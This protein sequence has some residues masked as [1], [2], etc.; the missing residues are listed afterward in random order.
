MS[1]YQVTL[2]GIPGVFNNGESV[3]FPYRKAEGIC[4]YLCV[5]KNANRDE[6]ISIFWGSS[7]EASG[8]KNLRQALFQIRQSMDTDVILMQGK[9][10]L[11]LNS[12]HG[13]HIDWDAPDADFSL[14]KERFLDFF[15]LKDCPE[16]EAWVENK[17][18]LQ[19]TRCLDYIKGQLKDP[20]IYHEIP[21]LR[22]LIDTW[23]YWKPWD[24]EMV[25]TGMR[26]YTQ[27]EKYDLGIQLYH[28][29]ERC[30]RKDLEEEPSHAVELLFRTLFHRK[31]VSLMRK[32]DHKEFFFGRLA[33]LQYIDERIFWFLNN[34][35][36]SSV[37]IEGEVGVGKT[38]LMQQIFEMNRDV[39][40]LE[41]VSHSYSAEAKFPLKSWRDLFNQ[42]EKLQNEGKLHLSEENAKLIQFVLTGMA[43]ELLDVVHDGDMEY[44]GYT[45]LE[46][47]VLTLLKELSGRWKIILYFDSLQ[48]MD[49]VS[50]RLLQRIMIEFGNNQVFMIATC[51]VDGQQDIRGFLAALSERDIIT[52]LSLSCFT[53]IETK[54]IIADVLQGRRDD[55][56]NARELF[57]RT[58]GNALVL[59]DTLNMVRQNGWK[60]GS[61]LPRI[62][63]LI[64][65][66]LESLTKQQRKVL[67]ALSVY[68][69]HAELEE[70]E[71]LVEMD[72]MELIEILEQLLLFHFVT[73]EAWN[74]CIIYKFTHRFYKDYVYQ[75]LSLGKRRLWH[76]AVA[77]FYEKQKDEERWL[78]LLPFTIFHY[79]CCGN[80]E[81][82]DAL[83]NLQNNL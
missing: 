70:L 6:L 40:I 35:S 2:L 52:T 18:N 59:M 15:Y 71:L 66:W 26:C 5:E 22:R 82:A 8:R 24:E 50:Q 69:E 14:C 33:E 75:Q 72:R 25:L 56:I 65:V 1:K 17:R 60:N 20:L 79:E 55:E 28:E 38:A 21:R 74:E 30:L 16:F 54:E 61:P 12:K 32:T 9:N 34:E 41:L 47:G 39:G 49:T 67:D 80:I 58:E 62:N 76:I 45:A 4:Y 46:N 27:V 83:R 78:E 53:E 3:H 64:Q 37:I 51:R 43:A 13:F 81:R 7:D 19:I 63:M 77:E 48:W 11:E 36:T 42:L 31:E 44:S 73:E 29:Y 57:L 23:A 68:V 10:G